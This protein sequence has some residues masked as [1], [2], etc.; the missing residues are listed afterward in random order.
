[1]SSGEG[2]MHRLDMLSQQETDSLS[3]V[4]LLDEWDANLSK[5]AKA[6]Y[7]ARQDNLAEN[8]L[9]IEVRH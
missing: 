7:S 2:M 9:L 6:E 5:D 1:M 3:K 4:M 8:H